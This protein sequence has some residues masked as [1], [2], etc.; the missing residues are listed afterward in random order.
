VKRGSRKIRSAIVGLGRIGSILEDDRL[1]EKPC[2]HAGALVAAGCVL[3]GGADISSERRELFARRWNC[4]SVY[5]DARVMLRELKP[6]VLH[7]ATHPD[8]HL[9]YVRL[10]AAE[11]VAC[12]VCEK[13]LADSLS[14]AK[15]IAALGDSGKITILTNHERRYSADYERAR[16][17][18]IKGRFGELLSVCAR[19]YFGRTRSLMSQLIHDGTHLADAIGFL[20]GG[21]LEKPEVRGCLEK[22]TGTAFITARV[23]GSGIP[24]LIESGAGRDYLCFE[25]DLAFA[26]GRIRIGNGIYEEYESRT[27]PYYE[28]FCSLARLPVPAFTKTGYFL[29]MAK[30][31][32]ACARDSLR[33]PL[34]N[35]WDGFQALRFILS[36]APQAGEKAGAKRKRVS[37]AKAQGRRAGLPR[38][39]KT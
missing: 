32:A 2:T 22:K 10:A 35:A 20:A 37:A 30:D 8:S 29:S 31:A 13:P 34:S 7:I 3:V 15:K 26:R 11:G 9:E 16:G 5:A 27:S 25:I 4:P 39:Q 24:V 38:H 23:A 33:R 6:D 28:G 19:L 14:A 36:L 21:F 17:R 18:V 1:R 12:V